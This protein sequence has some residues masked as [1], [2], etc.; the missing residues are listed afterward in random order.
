M[1]LNQSGSP[2]AQAILDSERP[3][4]SIAAHIWKVRWLNCCLGYRAT[5]AVAV[6]VNWSENFAGMVD[7][8]KSQIFYLLFLNIYVEN[9][10]VFI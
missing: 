8:K 9:G 10:Y 6:I 4:A 7:D 1:L 2:I 3:T 5:A